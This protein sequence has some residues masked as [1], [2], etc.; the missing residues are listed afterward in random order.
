MAQHY[1]TQKPL[2]LKIMSENATLNIGDSN[3]QLNVLTGTEDE[4]ALD[5]SHLEK[6]AGSLLT[7]M[8]TVT[9]VHVKVESLSLTEIREF[10]LQGI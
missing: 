1:F 9:R 8:A 5:I 7:T 3:Y 6:I 2:P 10:Q 4:K